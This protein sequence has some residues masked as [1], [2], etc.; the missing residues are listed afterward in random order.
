MVGQLPFLATSSAVCQSAYFH[1]PLI[2]ERSVVVLG[3]QAAVAVAAAVVVL[4]AAWAAAWLQLVAAPPSQEYLTDP[5]GLGSILD[6]QAGDC[7]GDL[8]LELRLLA[9][10]LELHSETWFRLLTL[11]S[12]Q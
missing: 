8:H 7:R 3:L 1:H 12:S 2:G 10:F 6:H 4:L 5:L 11:E 9:G